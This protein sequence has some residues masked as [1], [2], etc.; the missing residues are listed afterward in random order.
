MKYF[1]DFLLW[2]SLLV[3]ATW[4]DSAF[5]R[6][7][8]VENEV[9]GEAVS[10]FSTS[11]PP[12]LK[13]LGPAP[14]D[15]DTGECARDFNSELRIM[16]RLFGDA[17]SMTA[18]VFDRDK[19]IEREAVEAA[20]ESAAVAARQAE[21]ERIASECEKKAGIDKEICEDYLARKR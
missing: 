19:K 5:G 21:R 11:P 6:C 14:K 1:F 9:T 10:I 2:F 17:E 18:Y 8:I 20:A 4:A 7:L 13:I 15:P 16:D 3:T 12:H